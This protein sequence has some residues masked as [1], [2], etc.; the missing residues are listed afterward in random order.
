MNKACRDAY[1]WAI[2]NPT[3]RKTF[4]G[5][6]AFLSRWLTRANDSAFQRPA[7]NGHGKETFDETFQKVVADLKRRHGPNFGDSKAVT[8]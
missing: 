1:A 6:G 4:R 8:R 3:K 5:M 7:V 2:N